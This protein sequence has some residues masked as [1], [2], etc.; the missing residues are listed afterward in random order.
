M[1]VKSCPVGRPA[2]GLAILQWVVLVGR[3]MGN[4]LGDSKVDDFDRRIV[5]C[6]KKIFRLDVA[7]Q[8]PV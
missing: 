2:D 7:M 5:K 4:R 6:A 1:R 3:T 8:N